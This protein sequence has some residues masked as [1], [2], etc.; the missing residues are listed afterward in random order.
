[1][2]TGCSEAEICSKESSPRQVSHLNRQGE[3]RHKEKEKGK[4]EVERGKRD[5]R[6]KISRGEFDTYL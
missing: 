6:D 4:V 2:A 5:L 1:M 3:D